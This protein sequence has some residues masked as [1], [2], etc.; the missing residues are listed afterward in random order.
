[1]RK[2]TSKREEEKR[3]R[4]N[5]FLVGGVMIFIMVFSVLGYSFQGRAITDLSSETVTYNGFGFVNQDGFWVLD[6]NSIELTFFYNPKQINEID[7]KLPNLEHYSGK[8]LFVY[9]ES[10]NAKLE[11]ERNLGLFV[12]SF[13]EKLPDENC[14]RNSI[15]IQ[16]SERDEGITQEGNCIYIEG[17]R[18]NLI[19]LTDEFLFNT[20]EIRDNE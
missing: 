4:K 3:R 16:E 9:S 12:K 13:K 2:I 19:K 20:F 8:D 15:I 17:E 5:R 7:K 18:Q 10:E 6:Y 11:I 14:E 1:M